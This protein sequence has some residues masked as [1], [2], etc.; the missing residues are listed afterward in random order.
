MDEERFLPSRENPR[1]VGGFS[2]GNSNSNKV[3]PSEVVAV[4]KALPLI[5]DRFKAM[6]T[7]REEEMRV[8]D[9]DVL[10]PTTEEIV[11]LYEL[12]LS[13]LT[14]NSKPIITDL[15]IIAGEQREHGEGIAD[16][17]CARIIE[18]PVDQKLPS[19]YLLDSIV[20][21]IGREYIRHFSSR[22]PEAYRQVHPNLYPAMRHLFGTWSTVFPPSVLRKIEA[23]LLF[24]PSA[25]HQS[26]GLTSL[27][28]SESPRPTHG[29]HV[30]PKY[31][32][33]RRQFEHSTADSNNEHARGTSSTL[34]IYGQKPASGY[35][36]YDSDNAEGSLSSQVEDQRLS[37]NSH[38]AHYSFTL[39]AGRLLPSSAARLAKSSSP[40]T[41]EHGRS[42]SP[43]V[44]A[45][46]VDNSP[47]RFVE[48][49]SPS[50]IGFESGLRRMTGR[51]ELSDWP[52]NQWSYDGSYRRPET[53]SVYNNGRELQRPR[54]LID[55]YGSDRRTQTPNYKPLKVDV[56]GI[57]N[58]VG[59][60]AWQDTDEKEFDWEDMSPTLADHSRSNDMF[61]SSVPPLESFRSRPGYGTR[62]TAPL[63]SDFR[64]GNWSSLSQIS[65][66]KDSSVNLE[67]ALPI[68]TASVCFLNISVP[69]VGF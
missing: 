27:K 46:A 42:S 68:P 8:S 24:S 48:R 33:A 66:A 14:F 53:S 56:N 16:A 44:D 23:Q 39:G 1:Y 35:D 64:R 36:E 58:K 15:T 65:V 41:I 57:D 26:S 43:P 54:A 61:S 7:E 6:L 40:F 13:E 60:K 47:R 45:F 50:H 30:N 21:N 49:A 11:G 2:N 55:A 31:L 69:I 4:Q 3:M 5:L 29:I 9:G 10:P 17:I 63:D 18:A 34:T 52:R 59:T 38:P 62:D 37:S 28:A 22:L 25:N 19:L 67:D 12:V 51:E 32:E 20:K